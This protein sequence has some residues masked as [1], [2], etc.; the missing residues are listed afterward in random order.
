M[1][2]LLAGTWSLA[3]ICRVIHDNAIM[4]ATE[5][6]F[7]MKNLS[8]SIRIPFRNTIW[9]NATNILSSSAVQGVASGQTCEKKA[10]V[11]W[12]GKIML[13]SW[14]WYTWCRVIITKCL[15]LLQSFSNPL[16][17]SV[18][19]HSPMTP[20]YLAAWFALTKESE[21]PPGRDKWAQSFEKAGVLFNKFYIA[22]NWSKMI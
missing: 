18:F 4:Q 10:L 8:C 12:S 6:H 21:A 17:R 20:T 5:P 19:W 13:L 14:L 15:L 2:A 11:H 7:L 16:S 22:S 9:Y 3:C 1:C